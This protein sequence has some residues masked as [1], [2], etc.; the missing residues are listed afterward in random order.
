MESENAETGE[1]RAKRKEIL[2]FPPTDPSTLFKVSL[3]LWFGARG[4]LRY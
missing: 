3:E 1:E 2:S 4:G